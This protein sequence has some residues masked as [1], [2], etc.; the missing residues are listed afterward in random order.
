M[1][2]LVCFFLAACGPAP[3]DDPP[4][5]VQT[6][7]PELEGG[8]SWINSR[9]LKLA[10]LRGRV[11]LLNFFDYSCVNCLRVFPYLQEWQR[12]YADAG[13]VV[14]G[15][16]TPQYEFSADPRNVY[17]AV[18]RSGLTYPVVVD[19][20]GLIAEAYD[21][22]FWPRTFLVDQAGVVR[23]DHTGEGAYIETERQ[24][25]E[26]LAEIN[27]ARAFVPL[28]EPVHD[29]D[30]P[31]ATCYPIT[32]ELYLGHLRGALDSPSTVLTNGVTMY[33]LPESIEAEKVYAQ[34]AWD[35]QAEYLR[36][37][38]DTEALEDFILLRYDAVEV[39]AVMKPEDIYWKQ[40]FVQRDGAWLP[41]SL[42]GTDITYD[43]EGRSYVR[44]DQARMYNLIRHQPYGHHQLRLYT[45]GLGLSVY[46]FS[47]GTCVI[48]D[49][50]TAAP[51]AGKESP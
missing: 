1:I 32:P 31:D 44:V 15:V 2:G 29:F 42:A 43:D 48:P 23:F 27:P 10:D 28:M 33:R 41:R 49:A 24:V 35:N 40:V 13:L 25:Q 50:T 11:V 26:L 39:N 19:S 20:D 5:L 38:R 4:G 30:R 8:I 7:A 22:R 51:A 6:A 21:N 47:F 14:I 37:T 36:H 9:P 34:G 46:S 17:A 3:T 45:T 16:H 12:R 18:M